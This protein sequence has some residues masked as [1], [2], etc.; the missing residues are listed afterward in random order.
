[1]TDRPAPKNKKKKKDVPGGVEQ[2]EN[3]LVLDGVEYINIY[4][5]GKT[6]LGQMLAHFYKSPFLHPYFGS[7]NSME[8]FWHYIKTQEKDDRLRVMTGPEARKLGKTLTRHYIKNFHDVIT[9]ANFYKIEQNEKLKKLFVESTL[10]FDYYYLFGP[11]QVLVR[12][13]GGEWLL[14]SFTKIRTM[15]KEGERPADIDYSQLL[16][17]S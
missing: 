15:M 14:E 13:T 8:G 17:K 1:M 7:F 6:E 5:H 9:A 10:P 3:Y 4:L 12:P 16:K 2:I 11:G